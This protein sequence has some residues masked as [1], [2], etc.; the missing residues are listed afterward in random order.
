MIILVQEF[1]V[2]GILLVHH[3]NVT[4]LNYQYI[5]DNFPSEILQYIFGAYKAQNRP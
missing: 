2:L 3:G 1:E 4:L 5:T